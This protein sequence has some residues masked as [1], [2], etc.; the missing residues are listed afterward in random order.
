MYIEKS[1]N[2]QDRPGALAIE[3][4]AHYPLPGMAIPGSLAFS[5]DSRLVTY[6]L[7]PDRSLTRQLYA[8]EL[9]SGRE[10]LLIEPHGEGT[11]D[12]NVSLEEALRRERL[13][14]RETGITSYAWAKNRIRLMAPIQGE[15]Y[16][17]DGLGA[18]LK[19]ILEAGEQPYLDPQISPDGK[20]IA[21]VQEAELYAAPVEGGEPRQLTHGARGTGRT[22]GLA[23]YIAQEE[24]HRQHGFWWSPDS[25]QIAFTEVDETHIPIYR[26]MH[27]GKDVT[28]EIAQEDHRYPFAGQENARVRL[29]VISLA[30]GEPTWMDLGEKGDQY[31]ARVNW[32]G[33]DRLIVQVQNRQ[34]TQLD[35]YALDPATG[36]KSLLFRE[37]SEVWINLHDLFRPLRRGFLWAA[38]RSGFRHIYLYEGGGRLVRQITSGEWMVDDVAGVDEDHARVYFTASKESPLESHLYWASLS[39]GEPQRITRE[40]GL[41]TVVLDQGCRYYLDTFHA[42]DQPPVVTLRPLPDPRDLS[43]QAG[44]ETSLSELNTASVDVPTIIFNRPDPRVEA[45]QLQP[46]EL[47][48]LSNRQG[49]TLY[50]AVYHPDVQQF[51][52]GPYPTIVYVYG[53]PHAQLVANGWG[54]TVN[55]RPQYLRSLGYL[56]FI[57]DNRGSARRGLAFEAALRYKMSSVEV[58]DQVDGVRWLVERGLADP[59]RVGIYGWSYGGY[60]SAMCLARAADTFQVAVA[61]APVTHWDGYDTHYTERY[62]GLPQANRQGYE[63]SSVMHYVHHLR[64]KLLLVHCLID[65][66]VHFRHTARLINALITD[67]KPYDLLLFPDERHMPRKPADRVYMEQLICDYFAAHL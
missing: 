20:W 53:G 54:L 40:P 19:K 65:E 50:G 59:T 42:L 62:M 57:L 44:E 45:L 24:M 63:E 32:L 34:Q 56:V 26:I 33:P 21:Y 37:S 30:G 13:R 7:S 46:P 47:V 28:G 36:E 11:T 10:H 41:H 18:P 67:R 60:M 35:L 1:P 22:H 64:G 17:Q 12:E 48:S 55:M 25:Q 6:L 49:D 31:L 29:G 52:P 4:I 58:E 38:E 16:V 8:F 3:E 5:P 23:E 61:G 9:E 15:V 43:R 51:G 2:P 27:Q 66:N 14:Q 39:G